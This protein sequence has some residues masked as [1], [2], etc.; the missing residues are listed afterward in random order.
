MLEKYSHQIYKI[1]RLIIFAL[2]TYFALKH[3]PD[4]QSNSKD[5]I[6]LTIVITILFIAVD[7]YYPNIYF[8]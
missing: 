6:K 7:C 3:I 2:L 5:L 4:N 8:D 1:V